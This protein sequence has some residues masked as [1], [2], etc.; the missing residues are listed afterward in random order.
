MSLLIHATPLLDA[1]S[2]PQ[3]LGSSTSAP[4]WRHLALNCHLDP[5][6]ESASMPADPTT[7]LA[8]PN[9]GEPARK[10]AIEPRVTAPATPARVP[11]VVTPPLVPGRTARL[12]NTSRGVP[13]RAMPTSVAQV[14]AVAAA[15]PAVITHNPS[16]G[17]ANPISP[18]T[19][20]APPLANTWLASRR[21][22]L[23]SRPVALVGKRRPAAVPEMKNTARRI[24]PVVPPPKR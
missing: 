19:A 18:P 8:R 4:Q 9:D 24:P 5:T 2:V 23:N 21:V 7:E 13:P 3:W 20:A 22:A 11:L 16:W 6:M 14:S 10:P 1:V 12:E 17:W 15:S